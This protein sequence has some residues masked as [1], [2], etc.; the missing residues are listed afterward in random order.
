MKYLA[1]DIGN[2]ICNL[3]FKEFTNCVSTNANVS[4]QEVNTF[5]YKFQKPN[6]LGITE[7][8]Y[9]LA[10]YFGIKSHSVVSGLCEKWNH[11]M[12]INLKVRRWLEAL[13]DTNI[14]LLS[15]IG[16]EHRSILDEMFGK[17]IDNY[18]KFYSCDVGARKPT[19][20]YYKLFLEMYPQ[21]NNALYVDD[22]PE[23]LEAGKILGLRPFY[24]ALDKEKNIEEKLMLIQNEL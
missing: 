13:S 16:V 6:D 10:D 22:R 8:Q 17:L 11:T 20:L 23:N 14:A 3:S 4:E 21:F 5:L 7:L 1:I 18:I 24:F 9:E 15:N 2:V 19:F 12:K